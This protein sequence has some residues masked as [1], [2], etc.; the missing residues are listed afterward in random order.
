MSPVTEANMYLVQNTVFV[1][2]QNDFVTIL[3][4]E[5]Y[6]IMNFFWC[7]VVDVWRGML[8]RKSLEMLPIQVKGIL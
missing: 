7:V 6:L 2:Y 1:L 3:L 5:I 4:P 8:K